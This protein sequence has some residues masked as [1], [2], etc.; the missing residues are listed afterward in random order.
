HRLDHLG[1]LARRGGGAWAGGGDQAQLRRGA[2]R[3]H[4]RSDRRVLGAQLLGER[5]EG[6]LRR[7]AVPFLS[8]GVVRNSSS[9]ASAVAARVR[10]TLASLWARETNQASNCDGGG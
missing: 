5:G 8:H 1:V 3:D 2:R 7:R 6:L 10:S 4:V 9:R